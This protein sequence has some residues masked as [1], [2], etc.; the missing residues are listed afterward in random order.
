[1]LKF[2]KQPVV[3][4]FESFFFTMFS[5]CIRKNNGKYVKILLR[6]EVTVQRKKRKLSV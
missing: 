3:S 6:L 1:L 2:F 5:R 4:S